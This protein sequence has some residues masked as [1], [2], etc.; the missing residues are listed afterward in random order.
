MIAGYGIAI[1]VGAIA[2][3]IIE[4]GIR[5]GLRPALAAGAG[6]ATADGVYATVAAVAGATVAAVLAPAEDPLRW[7]GAV[8]L[9]A[10]GGWGMWRAFNPRTGDRQMGSAKTYTAFLGLTLL[11]PTTVVYF[12]A[13]IIGLQAETLSTG[14]TRAAFVGAAFLASLSWQWLLAFVSAAAHRQFTDRA[15]TVTG[16]VGN[17]I[18]LGFAVRLALA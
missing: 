10:I 3:L 15:I 18:V 7:I 2:V 4:L 5:R 9:F 14:Q 8:A 11:N 17:L 12:A 1:P 13:L 6:A 16:V